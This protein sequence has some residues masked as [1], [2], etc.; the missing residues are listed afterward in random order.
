M[1]TLKNIKYIG[2]FALAIGFT[3]C[4]DE[5]DF[6]EFLDMPPEDAVILPAL[7]AGSADFS[8]YISLG[9]SFT[10]GY[11][12]G[13]LFMAAQDNSFPNT[14]SKQ[15]ANA[16]GGAFTQPL[17]N[18]NIGGLVFGT[19]V[20]A[21]PR[22]FF[23]GSGPQVLPATP[24]TDVTNSLAADGSI[25]KNVGV[26]G[27]K[28]THI[29]FNGYAGL[30][31]YFGRFANSPTVSM[32]EYAIAQN[33]TFFT[34]SEIGGN[35]VLGYATTG[36]DGT[37][38]ITPSATFDFVFNDMVNQLTAVCPNGVVTNVPY[39]TDLP[40]FTTVP[41]NPVPLDAAT[42]TALNQGYATYNGGLQFAM[43]NGLLT[44]SEVDQ[45][46]ITF[47]ASETN[48]M[49]LVDETL[50]DLTGFGIPSYR[51]ATAEDLFVLPLSTLIPQGYGTQIP[52]E[53][54]W[55]LLPSEQL[56]IKT[57]TDGYN[58]TI[59]SVASTKGLALVN[60]N[61]IL[62]EASST[63]VTFDTYNLTTD[64]VTG[65]LVSLDGIHLTARGYALM[66]NKFL[67]AIDAT[68]GSN[69]VASGNVSIA[70]DFGVTYSPTLQ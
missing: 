18:D 43:T 19:T 30:N 11:T 28:S 17:M 60:L 12:D 6:E 9:A 34:L 50:T 26:P 24:T 36:G 48:A 21:N 16:N 61:V 41:H 69:F 51:Q 10:S 1:K 52:L 65:G 57:A 59:A 40:H 3:S 33:P 62:S 58:A 38:P 66:A 8:N 7:T 13:A 29:D 53:D 63:G 35:D 55:A 5:S 25:F 70:D 23:N 22:L 67:E 31:P 42:A 37:D 47:A 39:I 32:L 15:F 4:N 46:T 2:L 27:A 49:V 68:Y 44:Q 56:E 64:L 14:L 45:R 20:L 54:K